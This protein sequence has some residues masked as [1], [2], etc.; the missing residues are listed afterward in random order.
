MNNGMKAYPESERPY[1]RCEEYGAEV[2]SDAEL[3]AVVLRSGRRGM[4]VKQLALEVLHALG[5]SLGGLCH[6]DIAELSRISGIGRVKAIQLVCVAQISKR[7]WKEE[8]GQRAKVMHVEEAAAYYMQDLRHEEKEHVYA[9]MLDT[10][11]RRIGD[12]HASIGSVNTS[13]VPVREIVR[14]ALR[15]DAVN[16]I[17]VH[18]HPSGDP[19]PSASDREIN[20]NLNLACRVSGLTMVDSIIIGDGRYYSFVEEEGSLS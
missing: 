10:K 4:D 1:E 12:Y 19:T 15:A 2:L 17:L 3:L 20:R 6:A 14:S 9:L 5:G 13:Q 18:N 7:I 16:I 11:M 8:A